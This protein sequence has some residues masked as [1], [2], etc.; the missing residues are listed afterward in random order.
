MIHSETNTEKL[1]TA[2]DQVAELIQ[3]KSDLPYL[4][5]LAE[6]GQSI[7]DNES[8]VQLTSEDQQKMSEIIQS[9]PLLDQLKAEEIRKAFQLAVLKGMKEATQPHHA[10]TPDAVSLFMGHLVEQLVIEKEKTQVLL[11]PAVGSGNLLTAVMNQARVSIHAVGGDADETLIKLAFVNANMQQQD[12]DLFHQDSI[13]TPY[14]HNVDLVVSDLPI[15]YY[16]DDQK[17]ATFN[18][19]SDEGHSFVHHLLIEQSLKH[20]KPGGFLIFLIPNFLFE[21]EEAQNLH[22]FLKE[23]ALIYSLLQL[24]KSMFKNEQQGKSI[25]VIR[26]RA[27]G[28]I[29]PRQAL[30]A[31]LPSFTNQEALSDMVKNINEWFSSYLKKEQ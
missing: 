21:T 15:G 1:Y 23:E 26:K 30:L 18:L 16:P 2:L 29:E 13:A 25:F 19:Q 10:M 6:G 7:L 17:A 22:T 28:I 24:P 27:K 8:T 11:D 12:V 20:V 14:V 3:E 4:E 9:A 31:E 5:A